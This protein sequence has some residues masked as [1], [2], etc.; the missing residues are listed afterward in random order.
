MCSLIISEAILAQSRLI[1]K[2]AKKILKG[3]GRK[4]E[5]NLY[6]HAFSIP[7]FLHGQD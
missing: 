1:Q 4:Q 7:H 5:F 2:Y 6:R 3:W